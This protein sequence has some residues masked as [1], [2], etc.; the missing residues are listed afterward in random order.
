MWSKPGAS[1]FDHL[2]ALTWGPACFTYLEPAPEE[3]A[4]EEGWLD[5][6]AG[7]GILDYRLPKSASYRRY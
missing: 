7:Q 4:W 3:Q 6:L 2:T 1:A 5:W